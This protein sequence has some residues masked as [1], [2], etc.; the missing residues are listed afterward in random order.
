MMPWQ[1]SISQEMEYPELMAFHVQGEAAA[2]TCP[3]L[4]P[5][6]SLPH[7]LRVLFILGLLCE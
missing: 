1:Y 7:F 6:P 3:R 4:P 2:L 5:F